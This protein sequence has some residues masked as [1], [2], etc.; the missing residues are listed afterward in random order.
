[1]LSKS[2]FFLLFCG[3]ATIT[4]GT[5]KSE[6]N[7]YKKAFELMRDDRDRWLNKIYEINGQNYAESAAD[8]DHV[9]KLLLC[10]D[11]EKCDL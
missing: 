7:K 9:I 1:M 4:A 10:E 6:I 5:Y 11:I 2:L 3:C 8:T